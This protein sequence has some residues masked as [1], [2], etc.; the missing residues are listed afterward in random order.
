MSQGV[1]VRKGGL[2]LLL[3]E[4]EGVTR[5]NIFVRAGLG[6]RGSHNW[7]VKWIL[8]KKIEKKIV[9]ALVV[10]VQAFNRSTNGTETGGT[11]EFDVSLVD[12]VNSSR[13]RAKE[14]D[15]VSNHQQENILA[16]S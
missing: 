2:P 8:K 13:T 6:I 4:G 12:R 15:P 16:V 10:V 14:G 7:D 5:G 9:L 1:V 3:R 11:C